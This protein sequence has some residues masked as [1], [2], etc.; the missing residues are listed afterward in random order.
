M[1]KYDFQKLSTITILNI[2]GMP[3]V[4]KLKKRRFQCKDFRKTVFTQSPLVKRNCQIKET[5]D[6]SPT[7]VEEEPKK[8]SCF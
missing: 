7:K 4:L 6:N 1:F 3:T 2:Q 8:H 5:S